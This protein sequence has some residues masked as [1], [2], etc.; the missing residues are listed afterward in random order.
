MP[1]TISECRGHASP[2]PPAPTLSPPPHPPTAPAAA[3]TRPSF[4][5]WYAFAQHHNVVVVEE[6]WD[7]IYH[8][9]EPFWGVAPARI[10][11]DA[12]GFE[13]RI[14]IRGPAR[15]APVITEFDRTPLI[16][17]PFSLAHMRG[18]FVSNTTLATDFCHQPDLQALEGIFVEPISVSTTSRL[19]PIF[20]GSK[21]SVNNDILLPAP[22]YWNEEDR[23][24]GAEGASIPWKNKHNSAIWRGVATGGHN[25]ASNWRSFQRHRFVAMNN[26]GISG[27]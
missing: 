15:K 18:G 1:V 14:E 26:A 24:T 20:G 19:L 23:F 4:D 8:D 25:H 5:K 2:S 22:M 16:A 17:D 7:Q 12:K 3:A 9:L 10:R 27:S 21:L 11:A 6:F 13:M